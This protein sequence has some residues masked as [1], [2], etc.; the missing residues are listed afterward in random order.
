MEMVIM[1]PNTKKFILGSFMVILLL[2][3]AACAKDNDR[4]QPPELPE[5]TEPLV[6][7]AKFDLTLK[8]NVDVE[9]INLISVEKTTFSNA[10]LD[11]PEPG[12]DYPAVETPGY[13]ILLEAEGET[14]EYRAS[15]ERVVQVPP[16][17]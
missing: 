2:T 5:D 10:S 17:E 14:Y 12:A 1:N 4:A 6:I 16:E 13:I 11:I 15:G 8:T 3:A 9:K 7:L